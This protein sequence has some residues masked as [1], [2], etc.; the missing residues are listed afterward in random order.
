L[1]PQVASIREAAAKSLQKIAQD[2]GPEWTKDHLLPR[3]LA[4]ARNSHYLYRM[5]MLLSLS[6]LAPLVSHDV[7]V[8][9]MLPVVLAAAKDKVRC[10]LRAWGPANSRGGGGGGCWVPTAHHA[11]AAC[12]RGVVLLLEAASGAVG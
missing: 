10:A 5:T 4:M 6:L 11:G 8:S 3:I 2:F 7:L 9:Q 1:C 12:G